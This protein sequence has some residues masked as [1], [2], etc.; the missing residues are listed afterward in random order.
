MSLEEINLKRVYTDGNKFYRGVGWMGKSIVYEEV[1]PY[2]NWRHSYPRTG[3]KRVRNKK[4]RILLKM[5][6]WKFSEIMGIPSPDMV[7]EFLE[8]S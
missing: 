7:D 6:L 3:V 2:I 1:I 5:T 4:G 8:K